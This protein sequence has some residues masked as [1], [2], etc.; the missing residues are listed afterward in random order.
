MKRKWL[1][2]ALAAAVACAGAATAAEYTDSSLNYPDGWNDGSNGGT[3][4]GA[5][6]ISANSGSGYAGG[7]IWETGKAEVSGDVVD[8]NGNAFGIIGKGDGSSFTAT[9][10]FRAPLAVGDSFE[11]DM[12]VNWDCGYN[13]DS[14]K[15]IALLLDG[16]DAVVI[17]H[18]AFPGPIS[19]NGFWD[20]ASLTNYGTGT[21]HWTILAKDETTVTVTGTARDGVSEPYSTDIELSSSALTGFRLQSALQKNDD[22]TQEDADKRQS[23]F[24][25]FKL[26]IAGE[27]PE[28]VTLGFSSG[29]WAVSNAT[30]ALSYT[31]TRSSSAGA[32]DVTVSSS[33][34]SFVAG[35]TVSFADGE[36]EISFT[37]DATL[38][39]S[40][41]YAKITASATG[42][43]PASYEVRG[44]QYR[45]SVEKYEANPDETINFWMNWDDNGIALDEAKVTIEANPADSME[46]PSEWTWNMEEGGAYVASSFVAISSG[47]LILK[48]AGVQ[49]A[50]YG[51]TVI[52]AGAT[53]SGPT[54]LRTGTT[55]TYTAD[56]TLGSYEEGTFRLT[57]NSGLVTIEPAEVVVT[58]SGPISFQ[59]SAG[60]ET[61]SVT[62]TLED[63]DGI[64]GYPELTVT[65]TEAPDYSKYIA[66]DD[67]SLYTDG[68]DFSSTGE[69]QEG[70]GA[71][72]VYKDSAEFGGALITTADGGFPAIL[73]EGS[74]FAIYAN[75]SN[76]DYAIVRPFVND[77]QP[78]QEA[79]IEFVVPEASG[80]RYIQFARIWEGTPYNRCEIWANGGAVGIN[81]DGG[82]SQELGWSVNARRVVASLK[83]AADGS[84]YTLNL[85]GY[86]EGS[87][88]PDD[89]FQYVINADVGSWGEG[90]QGI[91]IGG[92]D[93]G[94]DFIFNTLS[95]EQVEEPVVE[96]AIGWAAGV[97]NPDAAGEYKFAISA[98]TDDIGEVALSVSPAEGALSLS[99]D[100][101]DLTGVTEASF[102]VSL[103]EAI[104]GDSFVIT[105][106]P[107]DTSVAP[108]EYNVTV[109]ATYVTLSS[110]AWEYPVSAGEIWLGL[111]ASVSKYGTYA[112]TSSDEAVLAVPEAS[113]AIAVGSPDPSWFNV[114]IVGPGTATIYATAEGEETPA[115]EYTF[116]VIADAPSIDGT[117]IEVSFVDGD[118]LSGKVDDTLR[119][120]FTNVK[121][122]VLQW[123]GVDAFDEVEVL[124]NEAEWPD[125]QFTPSIDNPVIRLIFVK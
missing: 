10:N 54:S 13:S 120:Q 115:A 32:L 102:T 69:G 25:N 36:A 89:V 61:G 31:L 26:T 74:A 57:A 34:E 114:T 59:V 4:F 39:G 92:Y 103:S 63:D 108:I 53:L 35:K 101:V 97:W 71:W 51:V 66:Y 64:G 109:S 104:E 86:N 41:N 50:D 112:I 20:N 17:N 99:T 46:L 8:A 7:G 5:W 80:S 60:E 78:G 110:D 113:E 95:I 98:T 44:P 62:L 93:L 117:T 124:E 37:L 3:G 30:Q 107:A 73:S 118:G 2:L 12:A 123:N 43:D 28:L 40:G 90:L 70:F 11:F 9:R 56:I 85:A 24:N 47:T 105:A 58:E 65:I 111:S 52:E 77:L 88:F 94:S 6:Q 72:S 116:T 82:D 122:Q 16:K 23:Y 75:G 106:T 81:V 29:E 42:C 87:E 84:D 100:T 49:F 21:M 67:A 83:R 18:D 48:Y 15:G 14:K 96:R 79:S 22:E 125:M 76:P 68:F 121:A 45:L 19:V 27:L 91:V 38:T 33:D 119:D 55:A 1:G